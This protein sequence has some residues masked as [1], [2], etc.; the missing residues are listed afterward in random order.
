MFVNAVS[1]CEMRLCFWFLRVMI[2]CFL[3]CELGYIV[4]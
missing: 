1:Y 3:F 2:R 4:C